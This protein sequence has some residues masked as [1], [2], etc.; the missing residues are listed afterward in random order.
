MPEIFQKAT[1]KKELRTEDVMQIL[2]CS[3]R[4]VQYLRDSNQI[5][6]HQT[7]RTIRY[8]IEAVD[9]FLNRGKVVGAE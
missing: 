2:Q 8:T 4:H 9:D 5:E 6:F 3:R 7:A 1:R